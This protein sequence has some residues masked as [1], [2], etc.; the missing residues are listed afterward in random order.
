MRY[1]GILLRYA[2]QNP[3]GLVVGQ[4]NKKMIWLKLINLIALLLTT[5]WFVKNPDWEPLTVGLGLLGALIGQELR[6]FKTNKLSPEIDHDRT[7]FE[8]Y[9]TILPEE[10]LFVDIK[11]D[12][13]IYRIRKEHFYS[14]SDF[15]RL[16]ERPEGCYLIEKVKKL[17]EGFE[18]ALE[19]LRV[20]IITHFSHPNNKPTEVDYENKYLGLCPDLKYSPMDEERLLY[21][22]RMKELD[23]LS[24]KT[25]ESYK[26]FRETIKEKLAI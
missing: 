20:F 8:R 9:S 26:V 11:M 14:L 22:K 23:Q 7:L 3:V 5:A 15:L 16:S 2:S 6:G 12:L 13:D 19:E 17:H 4:K 21:R 18:F 25:Y 24:D 10:E 1:T